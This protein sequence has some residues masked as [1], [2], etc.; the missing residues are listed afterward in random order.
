M[1]EESFTKCKDNFN[2]NDLLDNKNFK[3]GI[4]SMNRDLYKLNPSSTNMIN[5]KKRRNGSSGELGKIEEAKKHRL[6]KKRI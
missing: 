2:I 3:M 4:I 5:K 6:S 1:K